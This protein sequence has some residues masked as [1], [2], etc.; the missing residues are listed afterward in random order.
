MAGK[1]PTTGRDRLL[2]DKA[3]AV[4]DKYLPDPEAEKGSGPWAAWALEYIAQLEDRLALAERAVEEAEKAPPRPKPDP[5]KL[6]AKEFQFCQ[7]YLI[8]LNGT[9]A[10][11]RAGYSQKTAA[12]IAYENLRKPHIAA[13]IGELMKERTKRVQWDADKMFTALAGE[14]DADIA[15]LYDENNCFKPVREWPLVWRMGLVNGVETNEL[16]EGTGKDRELVGQVVKVKFTER[17]KVKELLGKHTDVQAFKD[18]IDVDHSDP[19]SRLYE[20]IAGTG[21][22]PRSPELAAPGLGRKGLA[23]IRPRAPQIEGDAQ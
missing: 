1:T 4:A 20:Q 21:I 14:A 7:E 19:L 17:L 6:S 22:R 11:I 15:D 8:D 23:T 18:R 13:C 2:R 3:R 16:W 5:V 12:V 9:Q 10:A